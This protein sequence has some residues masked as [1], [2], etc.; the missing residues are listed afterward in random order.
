MALTLPEGIRSI[1]ETLCTASEATLIDVVLR[2]TKERMML[3][4][5]IDT[6]KGVS[7]ELCETINRALLKESET[8]SFL[9]DV[10]SIEVSSPG[11]DRPL[12][13]SWQYPRN[14]GRTLEIEYTSDGENIKGKFTLLSANETKISLKPKGKGIKGKNAK[15]SGEDT[16]LT[17]PYTEIQRAIVLLDL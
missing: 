3:E 15:D 11:T 12:L 7:L 9:N 1:L 14:I 8:N 17:I 16:T 2:G 6:P 13:Y 5:F 4:L 10:R